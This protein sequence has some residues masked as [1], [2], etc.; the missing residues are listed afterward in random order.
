MRYALPEFDAGAPIAALTGGSA[1]PEKPA[2]EKLA[3]AAASEPAPS[4]S[5]SGA[6]QAKPEPAKPDP[7]PAVAAAPAP[8]PTPT[9]Q[10]AALPPA[11]EPAPAAKPAAPSTGIAGPMPAVPL[12][13]AEKQP[14]PVPATSPAPAPAPSVAAVAPV[15]VPVPTTPPA[16]TATAAPVPPPEP[17]QAK[18]AQDDEAAQA[19]KPKALVPARKPATARAAREA[20]PVKTDAQAPIWSPPRVTA[21]PRLSE[22]ARPAP[23]SGPPIDATD[24]PP[25]DGATPV[26]TQRSEAPPSLDDRL[27]PTTPDPRAQ[28]EASVAALPL[29]PAAAGSGNS[30]PAR[31]PAT[32]DGRECRPYTSTTSLMGQER[33]VSGL[34]CRLP[35]GRWKLVSENAE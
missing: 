2:P 23:R 32:A 11:T 12:G 35:D 26:P 8:A 13:S 34:A 24:L 4:A 6:S 33:R 7:A 1:A 5:Q 30:V 9:P 19:A 28:R 20:T 21:T 15:P 10:T 18:P 14:L 31:A 22:P 25:L 16:R 27:A 29:P 17:P 3:Q